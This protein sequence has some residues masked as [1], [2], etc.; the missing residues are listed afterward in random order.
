MKANELLISARIFRRRMRLRF[1]LEGNKR[2]GDFS[3]LEKTKLLTTCTFP[4]VATG[5]DECEEALGAGIRDG[6]IFGYFDFEPSRMGS[7]PMSVSDFTIV[8]VSDLYFRKWAV[9]RCDAYADWL[10]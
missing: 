8:C 9:C 6:T 3:L 1:P 5:E 10:L 2:L 4:V 7:V